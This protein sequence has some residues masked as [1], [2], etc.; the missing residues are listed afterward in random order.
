MGSDPRVS[1]L[2][3]HFG[4]DMLWFLLWAAAVLW[5]V[6]RCSDKRDPWPN[7]AGKSC[8]NQE[9]GFLQDFSEPLS[10]WYRLRVT[11]GRGYVCY[12]FVTHLMIMCAVSQSCPM[13][14]RLLCPWDSPGKN[15]G[16]GCHFLLQGIFSTQRLNPHLLGL[17]HWEAD[18][19][20][21]NHLGSPF[22]ENETT[23]MPEYLKESYFLG[24]NL[25]NI[26]YTP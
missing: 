17:L 8:F 14:S 7:T 18:S 22:D 20:P 13:P 6:W 11:G 5:A 25:R 26:I 4:S 21:L 23:L 19:L 9:A 24:C 3:V 15:P 12:I 1:P 2:Y 16:V 10:G